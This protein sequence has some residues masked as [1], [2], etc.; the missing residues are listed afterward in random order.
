MD[1][2]SFLPYA[3]G[4]GL[5]GGLLGGLLGIG[6]SIVVIPLLSLVLGPNQQLYQAAAM[7]MNVAVAASA[8]I[9]HMRE[10]AVQWMTVG[11]LLPAGVIGILIGV[12]F[13]NAIST[14]HLQAIFAAFLV[15]IGV[16]ECN[17]LLRRTPDSDTTDSEQALP[18]R[19]DWVTM[20]LIGGA[21]GIVSGLLGIGG[22]IF[23]IPLLRRITRLPI[24]DAISVSSATMLLTATIGSIVKNYSLPELTAPDGTALTIHASLVIAGG[25]IP[26]AF[27][28]SFIGASMTHR[29]P[30]AWT[31]VI[32]VILILAAA[33]KMGTSAAKMLEAEI[34]AD[35]SSES[36]VSSALEATSL[37]TETKAGIVNS[38]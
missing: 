30:I 7:L 28:G 23:I 32:F 12:Q 20:S 35:Y 2:W 15:Y 25:M 24:R 14:A 8:T 11:R 27:V 10:K 29:I 1:H 38:A 18:Q 17:R 33:L 21:T 5:A 3:L 4:I 22:G 31:K 9:K 16:S 13:S 36:A 6:G 37:R 19:T 34:E 26:T